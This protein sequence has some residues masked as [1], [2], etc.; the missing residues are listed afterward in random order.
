[1]QWVPAGHSS[2]TFVIMDLTAQMLSLLRQ[3]NANYI[4]SYKFKRNKPRIRIMGAGG[5]A[6][7]PS[8]DGPNPL[9][10]KT[11]G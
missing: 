11:S 8:T 4:F 10:A 9:M 2:M 5:K 1:M 6:E 3:L 7:V